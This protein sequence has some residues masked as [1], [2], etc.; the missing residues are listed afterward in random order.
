MCC[1][2]GALPSFQSQLGSIGAPGSSP[3]PGPGQPLSIPA[4]FDW[5]LLPLPQ[6]RSTRRPFNPSLVRL[7]LDQL[8]TLWLRGESFNPSLVRL[9]PSGQRARRRARGSLSIPAWFDWRLEPVEGIRGGGDAF[10][11]SLV[12]LAPWY[13]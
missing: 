3:G 6:P 4:W 1:A 11:P 13:L 7:A 12:R 9:A 2:G 8:I 5:R 10:N